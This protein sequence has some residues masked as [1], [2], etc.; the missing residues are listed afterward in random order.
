MI[1]ASATV[2]SLIGRVSGGIARS[3]GMRT[4]GVLTG[5]AIVMMVWLA[6]LLPACSPSA[7]TAPPT[8]TLVSDGTAESSPSTQESVDPAADISTSVAA[9]T[10]IPTPTPNRVE[11]AVEDVADRTGLGERN[12]FGLS[13]SQWFE[14]AG[15]VLFIIVAFFLSR[16][17]VQQLLKRI[18]DR[19]KTNLDDAIFAEVGDELR[20]L[21]VLIAADFAVSDLSFLGDTVRT[22]SNDL[23]FLLNLIILTLM[24][25][26]LI[27]SA[28]NQ[29]IATLE[30]PEDR[31]RLDPI[32]ISIQRFA[33]FIVMILALSIGLA[34]FGANTNALYITLLVTGLILS[35]AARDII[36]DALSGFIILADQPFREGDSVL[37]Q[38]LNTWGDVLEIGTRT[39][40]IRTSD[41]REFIVPNSQVAKGH[42]VNYSYPDTKYRMQTDIGVAYGID[43]DQIRKTATD[44]VR[45]V[46]G[47]LDDEPVDVL[48]AEFGNSSRL[49]RVRWWIASFHEHWPVLDLVNVALESAFEQAGIEMPY[50]TYDLR[51]HI[52]DE[53]GSV[54]RPK[55]STAQGKQ[56]D[57]QS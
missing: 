53:G 10:P 52:E 43:I 56:K 6:L 46:K 19:T 9:R 26:G 33:Y 38:D 16:L 1:P 50:E 4:P 30:T 8:S 7:P 54:N 17:L 12:I 51:V 36:S 2:A 47:V 32:I 55:R 48:F 44:A 28:S 37:I 34:H 24:A 13:I 22:A 5:A 11:R 57:D 18:V 21:L 42:I 23:F 25:L 35:L 31:K 3:E 41:N 39:T 29:Y 40:R 27:R 15:A 20:W 45:G 14:I 49:M